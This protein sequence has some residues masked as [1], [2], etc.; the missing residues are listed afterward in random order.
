MRQIE[1][2][3]HNYHTV[4]YIGPYRFRRLLSQIQAVTFRLNTISKFTEL[5]LVVIRSKSAYSTKNDWHRRTTSGLDNS[6]NS[7]SSEEYTVCQRKLRTVVLVVLEK[8]SCRG[9]STT[10][11]NLT[12]LCKTYQHKHTRLQVQ[13]QQR[14]KA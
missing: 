5:L 2:V 10:E 4:K 3:I 12:A 7:R 9:M 1:M 11:L 13:H 14:E 6:G 8:V